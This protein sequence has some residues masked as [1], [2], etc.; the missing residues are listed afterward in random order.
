[1]PGCAWATFACSMVFFV[2]A[3]ERYFNF[4]RDLHFTGST[5]IHSNQFLLF[6]Y[7]CIRP[8]RKI[9]KS[10]D[11]CRKALTVVALVTRLLNSKGGRVLVLITRLQLSVLTGACWLKHITLIM[12]WIGLDGIDNCFHLNARQN[13]GI[14]F[15][16][17]PFFFLIS[18]IKMIRLKPIT[19][20]ALNSFPPLFFFM[21]MTWKQTNKKIARQ[22]DYHESLFA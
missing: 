11:L 18:V 12:R 16:Y 20:T 15:N 13:P 5:F 8:T 19:W 1:M 9:I 3:H 21:R 2:F 22:E 6:C 14:T 17:L 7:F 10:C 4:L